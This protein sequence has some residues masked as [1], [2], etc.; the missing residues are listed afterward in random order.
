M[1]LVLVGMDLRVFVVLLVLVIIL[2]IMAIHTYF[3][4]NLYLSY[5][6]FAF[7]NKI[8]YFLFMNLTKAATIKMKI[9]Q[10]NVMFIIPNQP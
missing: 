3:K 10:T 6:F 8:D 9:V 2:V 4:K 5:L 1:F 7:G